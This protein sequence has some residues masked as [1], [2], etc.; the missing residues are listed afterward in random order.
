MLPSVNQM[1]LVTLKHPFD[2][3]TTYLDPNSHA[4]EVNPSFPPPLLLIATHTKEAPSPSLLPFH[5]PAPNIT[6]SPCQMQVPRNMSYQVPYVPHITHMDN[7]LKHTHTSPLSSSLAAD[8]T[9]K[10]TLTL[11]SK[12]S[13]KFTCSP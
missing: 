1:L 7:Y 2:Q 11:L 8:F 5:E 12:L 3:V 6:T 9:K 4:L 10:N 13:H